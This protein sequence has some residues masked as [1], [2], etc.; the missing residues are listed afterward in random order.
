MLQKFYA[1]TLGSRFIKSLLAQTPIPHFECADDGDV[2]I[3][4]QYYF[5]SGRVVKATDSSTVVDRGPALEDNK[6]LFGVFRSSTNYY[7][8]STHYAL[9][10]YLRYLKHTTNINLMPFYN[11]FGGEHFS[12][13]Y[14]DSSFNVVTD[15]NPQ[16]RIIAVP[17]RY[18]H[19]YTIALECPTTVKIR[20]CIHDNLFIKQDADLDAAIADSKKTY[21]GLQFNRP[22][23]FKLDLPTDE[24][25]LNLAAQYKDQLYLTIQVPATCNSS[26]VVLEDRPPNIGIRCD[27]TYVRQYDNVYNL[28]LLR[29]NT[30]ESYAFVPRLMEYLLNNVIT[31]REESHKNISRLQRAL[32]SLNTPLSESYRTALIAGTYR[33]GTYDSMISTLVEE[34]VNNNEDSVKIFDNNLD[35]NKDIEALLASKGGYR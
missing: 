19:V 3:P 11:C 22:I 8:P 20:P 33:Y 5:K 14:F 4:G 25:K 29:M 7:D 17:I 6:Q 10:K 34:L 28:S 12:D 18:G 35:I 27:S 24:T 9:G 2:L 32:A 31:Y 30:Y 15:T 1:D 16:Y 26:I 21:T 13:F 23:L